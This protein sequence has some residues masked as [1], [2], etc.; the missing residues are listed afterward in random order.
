MAYNKTTWVN[1]SEPALSAENLNKIE[2]GIAANA[3]DIDDLKS[4]IESLSVETDTTLSQ[5]GVPA[6][7]K[8]VGDILNSLQLV[9]EVNY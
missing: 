9:D 2:D 1:G 4:E 6:D 8:A 5:E 7:A 3:D